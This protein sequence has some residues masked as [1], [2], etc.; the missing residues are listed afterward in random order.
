M[1]KTLKKFSQF[2]AIQGKPK[3]TTWYLGKDMMVQER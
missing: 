1:E 2:W 3:K